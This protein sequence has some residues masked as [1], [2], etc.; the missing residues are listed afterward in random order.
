MAYRI[1]R[2]HFIEAAVAL[3][4]IAVLF[5]VTLPKFHRAQ[6]RTRVTQAQQDLMTLAAAMESYALDW[7]N[8]VVRSLTMDGNNYPNMRTKVQ[9]FIELDGNDALWSILALNQTAFAA[10]L[11]TVPVPQ[12]YFELPSREERNGTYSIRWHGSVSSWRADEF[13]AGDMTGYIA[14]ALCP[15]AASAK[16]QL[17][18]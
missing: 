18:Q 13:G 9:A 3:T 14:T 2:S 15:A 12:P 6:V 11:E 16:Q 10:Y 17:L 4:V 5:A 7:P 1:R 8:A